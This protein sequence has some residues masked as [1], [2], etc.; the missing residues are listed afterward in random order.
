MVLTGRN[1]VL[2]DRLIGRVLAALWGAR[3]APSTPVELAPQ[4]R[5]TMR[6]E[7]LT[8]SV[9]EASRLLGISRSHAYLLTETGELP[10]IR[11]GSR[12]RIAALAI[13]QLIMTGVIQPGEP[14]Y[15]RNDNIS[16]GSITINSSQKSGLN[17]GHE[18]TGPVTIDEKESVF[19]E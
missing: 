18:K 17:A 16:S 10:C 11:L 8:Y 6:L 19:I 2:I 14:Q 3:S 5:P 13:E 1:T 4:G 7:R 15:Y 9:E 12:K